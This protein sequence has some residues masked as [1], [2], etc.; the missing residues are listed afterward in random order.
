MTYSA[1]NFLFAFANGTTPVAISFVSGSTFTALNVSDKT[2]GKINIAANLQSVRLYFDGRSR[3]FQR[4]DFTT[5][6]LALADLQ[7]KLDALAPGSNVRIDTTALATLGY[8]ITIEGYDPSKPLIV[9]VDHGDFLPLANNQIE[10]L[11]IVQQR[12]E[13][14]VWHTLT[15]GGEPGENTNKRE[16]CQS[17]RLVQ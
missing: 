15:S 8:Q 11:K 5:D 10:T 7:S 3:V 4:E 16:S 9:T 2:L 13:A 1:G 12:D 6:A 17:S 14:G